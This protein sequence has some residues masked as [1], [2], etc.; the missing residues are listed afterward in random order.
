MQRP[1]EIDLIFE[2]EEEE[3]DDNVDGRCPVIR[4]TKEENV[5]FC[6]ANGNKP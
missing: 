1:K 5:M 2:D 4:L 6:E 3:L